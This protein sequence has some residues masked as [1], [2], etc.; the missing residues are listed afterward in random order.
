MTHPFVSKRAERLYNRF[1]RTM[2]QIEFSDADLFQLI[3]NMAV[4]SPEIARAL[5]FYVRD[6]ICGTTEEMGSLE[7]R[8][9][10]MEAYRRMFFDP[11]EFDRYGV[12]E[13]SSDI[14]QLEAFVSR[15]CCNMADPPQPAMP[16]AARDAYWH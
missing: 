2:S 12:F 15:V 4:E 13:A 9:I 14:A 10:V 16:I 1:V 5:S 7:Y 3:G 11:T 8:D 6:I